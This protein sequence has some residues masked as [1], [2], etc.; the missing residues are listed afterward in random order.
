[1]IFI[2]D[3]AGTGLGGL[4]EKAGLQGAG[5]PKCNGICRQHLWFLSFPLRPVNS[6]FLTFNASGKNC[7][8][9]S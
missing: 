9:L 8:L 6:F 1:M 5:I 7:F 3:F 4:R 2:I